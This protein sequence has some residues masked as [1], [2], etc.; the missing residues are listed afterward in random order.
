MD[1]YSISSLPALSYGFDWSQVWDFY[2]TVWLYKEDTKRLTNL[3][4]NWHKIQIHG[5]KELWEEI[6]LELVESQLPLI[7][8]ALSVESQNNPSTTIIKEWILNSAMGDALNVDLKMLTGWFCESSLTMNAVPRWFLIFSKTHTSS[9]C[10][11][12]L[13]TL[14]LVAN[15]S[16]CLSVGLTYYS[17]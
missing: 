12:G 13:M 17:L 4:K 9:T 11:G 2:F 6:T 3:Q 8:K 14:D 15:G 10:K 5:A 16:I 1:L 7:I